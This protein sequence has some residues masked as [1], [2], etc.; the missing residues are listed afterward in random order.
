MSILLWNRA[1]FPM[2]ALAQLGSVILFTLRVIADIRLTAPILLPSLRLGSM[3]SMLS[4]I[5]PS[6]YFGLFSI[7][8]FLLWQGPVLVFS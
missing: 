4:I 1:S 7:S 3:R 5:K 2:L 6:A 8:G